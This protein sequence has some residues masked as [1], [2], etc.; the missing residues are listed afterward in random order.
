[1]KKE[2]ALEGIKAV[3]FGWVGTGPRH[4]K[5][6]A[7]HGA[8][9]VRIE[10]HTR[11][12]VL[13]L[14]P[15]FKDNIPGI[16][17]SAFFSCSNTSK[18]GVS[19][20]V[21]RPKGRDIALRLI[22]WADVLTEGFTPGTMKRLGLDYANAR[23]V[24]PDIIYLSTCQQGQDGPHARFAGYGNL[25]AA[26]AGMAYL[27]GWPDRDPT[28]PHGVY[29]DYVAPRF[30]LVCI[31][32]ALDY[33]QRT[34]KGFYIDL[35]QVESVLHCMAPPIMDY[36]V[37]GRIMQR[38]GNSLAY[39][40]PHGVYRCKGEDRWVAI[41]VFTDEEWKAFCGVIGEPT[42]A[43]E[44]RFVSLVKRKDSEDELN[45]LVSQWMI[46][47]SAEEVESMMQN[48]GIAASVVEDSRDLF[49]DPQLQ[50]RGYFRMLDHP[51]IGVH[52]HEGPG[53]ILTKTPSQERH[54]PCLGEHNE[55][56]YKEFIGLSD[57]EIADLIAE[58]VITSELNLPEYGR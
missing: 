3:D 40:A 48:A 52:A 32:A 35:S 2:Q 12:D 20:D 47:R 34:G 46:N 19:L 39:A 57:D 56:V 9:V 13:R 11:I 26:L 15:P 51:V 50:H 28:L 43:K 17:R 4:A 18:Y 45:A 29:N 1:M 30:G 37:N 10:S 21:S 33:R 54:A 25:G 38:S 7:D 6:L 53:F 14:Q 24:K 41:S 8:T 58:G 23:Q 36:F 55:Y 42:W 22:K 27:S 49:E 31:L 44:S 16:N 5:Y